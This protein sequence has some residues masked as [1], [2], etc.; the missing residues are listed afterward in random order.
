MAWFRRNVEKR[1]SSV[2]DTLVTAIQAAAGGGA[3]ASVGAGGGLEACA[4]AYGRALAAAEVSGGVAMRSLTPGL[5][6]MIGRELIRS[7]EVVLLIE[8]DN[9]GARLIPVAT[10][11][12]S[13]GYSPETWPY[14]CSLAGPTTEITR[15]VAAASVVH[16]RYAVEPARPWKGLSPLGVA[17]IAGR[18]DAEIAH[19]MGDEASGPRGG[20]IPTPKDGQDVSMVALRGDI[21]KLAGAITTVESTAASWDGDSNTSPRTDWGVR[22]LGAAWPAS[23]VDGAALAFRVV[24]AVCGVPSSLLTDESDGTSRRESWRQFLHGSVAPLGKVIVAELRAKLDESAGL[25]FQGLRASDTQGQ[26][27]AFA[28][29]IGSGETPLIPVDEARRLTGLE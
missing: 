27:R 18:L 5:L 29:L 28:A 3:S 1:E 2:T 20:L 15:T 12:V 9:T 19:M 25:D 23:V 7:G 4:G 13:G 21:K 11:D 10:Y 17:R 24:A 6:S 14:Q 22:R 16:L 8:V 26:S